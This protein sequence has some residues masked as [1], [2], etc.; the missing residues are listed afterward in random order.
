MNLKLLMTILFMSLM[1]TSISAQR[2]PDPNSTAVNVFADMLPDEAEVRIT[3]ILDLLEDDT[4]TDA[5]IVTLSSV[6]FYAQ[7]LTVA[8]YGTALFNAWGIGDADAGDGILLIIFRDDRELRL[9][10]GEGFDAAAQARAQ[11]VVDRDIIPLFANGEFVDG[12]EAGAIGIADHVVR[13]SRVVTRT[14]GD[15]EGGNFLWYLLGGIGGLVALV[16]GLNKRAAAKLAATPCEACGVSGQLEKSRV[17]IEPATEELEGMGERRIT[18]GACGYVAAESY[19]IDRIEVEKDE[20]QGGKS[21]GEGA[22]G[23]W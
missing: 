13:N 23:K 16:F 9:E 3:E 6:Q 11:E 7:S 5:T 20:F 15:G 17:V 1:G 10:L 8:E 14:S 18:C 22:S 21:E 2:F 19:T 4:G 12:I